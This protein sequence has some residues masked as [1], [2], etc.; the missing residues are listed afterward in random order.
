M[1]FEYMEHD[2]SGVIGHP[3]IRFTEAHLKSLS[4]QLLEGLRYLHHKA[5]LHRD[6]KGSNLLLNNQ[7]LLK[8]ADFGLARLYA[9]RRQG[10]YTNRVVTL[11]YRPPELLFGTTRYGPEIDTWG[12]GCILLELFTKRPVF[13]GQDEVHQLQV[14]NDVLGPFSQKRWPGVDKLPWYDLLLP[15]GKVREE[16]ETDREGAVAFFE[17]AFGSV[18]PRS[19]LDVAMGL[20]CYQP[21]RRSTAQEALDMPYFRELPAPER[22]AGLLSAIEGEWHEFEARR[23]RKKGDRASQDAKAHASAAEQRLPV[24]TGGSG[25]TGAVVGGLGSV[26]EA[27]TAPSS[28]MPSASREW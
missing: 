11:W 28:G 27:R 10:D 2:L 15:G 14:L 5:V 24:S 8:L 18:M 26:E 12:A 25:T 1:V 23:A 20:L 22:P 17:R 7:G 21:E 16:G 4:L 13:Q 3:Q 19:A 9:K 6:L